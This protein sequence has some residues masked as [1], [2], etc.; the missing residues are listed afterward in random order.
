MKYEK[1]WAPPPDLI[2]ELSLAL[3]HA[4]SPLL[5]GWNSDDLQ[6]RFEIY[7]LKMEAPLLSGISN[8][9]KDCH[10]GFSHIQDC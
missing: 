7:M 9:R 6:D 4:L 5:T 3:P 1:R 8:D 2:H 10:T